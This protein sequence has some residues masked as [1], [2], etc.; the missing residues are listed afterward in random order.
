MDEFIELL[1]EF[2]MNYSK[3]IDSLNRVQKFLILIGVSEDIS[4]NIHPNILVNID[5]DFDKYYKS[6]YSYG[7]DRIEQGY[8]MNN[9]QILQLQVFG[10]DK[11]FKNKSSPLLQTSKSK[12]S[13]IFKR[14][15]SSVAIKSYIKPLK[16]VTK[17]LKN[18]ITF[19]I[20][21]ISVNNVQIPIAISLAYLD[22]GY[23]EE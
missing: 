23:A 10:R 21:T 4:F 3:I 7:V 22:K 2:N 19:D 18:V 14:L 17:K 6:A 12:N 9:I 5:D 16:R 20:E 13:F 8:E 11:I 15:F 1:A